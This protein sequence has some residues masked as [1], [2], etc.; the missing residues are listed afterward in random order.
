MT[1]ANNVCAALR[2]RWLPLFAYAVL[3]FLQVNVE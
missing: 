1:L 3:L 2:V